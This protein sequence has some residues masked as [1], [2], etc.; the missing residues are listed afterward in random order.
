MMSTKWFTG[1]QVLLRVNNLC[2]Y[3]CMHTHIY[4]AC[5]IHTQRSTGCTSV[6]YIIA[7]WKKKFHKYIWKE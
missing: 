4:N 2:Y 3:I 7:A 5:V 6:K 1:Q